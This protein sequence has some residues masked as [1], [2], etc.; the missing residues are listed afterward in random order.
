MAT[1]GIRN[2]NPG[3]IRKSK[4]KWQGLAE[5]QPDSEFFTF[6]DPTYGIRAIA[7]ILI[8]YQDSYDLHSIE[9][10]INR[11][12][13]PVEN[14]TKAYVMAVANKLGVSSTEPVDVH[15]FDTLYA[16]V[17]AIIKHECGSQPYTKA[18]ITKG[19]V[20]AGVEPEAVKDNSIARTNTVKV[21]T[22]ATAI[23]AV[24]PVVATLEKVSEHSQLL[25][26][27][28]NMA[29]TV[30][31]VTLLLVVAFFVYTRWDDRRKGIR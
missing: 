30:L 3:N 26:T 2:N 17:E 31:T 16:L 11:W 7:R 12:A 14:N 4:D 29:P 10:I 25:D 13:P 24:N 21:A 8:K 27:L 15:Q 23:A 18:Q 9:K 22:G 5:H 6:K 19:L 1:R 28:S 20:L